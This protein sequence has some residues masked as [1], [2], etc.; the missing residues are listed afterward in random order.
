[1]MSFKL[2]ALAAALGIAVTGFGGNAIAGIAPAGTGNGEL[3]LT[4]WDQAGN[5]SYTRDLGVF[6]DSYG[7]Q[8]AT[9]AF[10]T[11]VDGSPSFT[12]SFVADAN[13]ASFVG[14]SSAADIANWRWS[15]TGYD[16]AGTPAINQVRAVYTSVTDDQ[17]RAADPSSNLLSNSKLSSVIAKQDPGI[18]NLNQADTDPAA[19]NSYIV[20]DPSRF[21]YAGYFDGIYL[22][23]APQLSPWATVGTAMNFIYATRSSS[24]NT[25]EARFFTYGTPVGGPSQWLLGA[26]GTVNFAASVAPIPEPG[27]WAMLLAGLVVVGSIARRR[28]ATHV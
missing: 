26:N 11:N 6:I 28:M 23:D 13:W 4:V 22:T 19:N 20:T 14:T 17:A 3:F 9:G 24:Q 16:N 8:N 18:A 25:P 1:M 15:V 7:T 2:K 27:E 10:T 12:Q 5:K 21:G